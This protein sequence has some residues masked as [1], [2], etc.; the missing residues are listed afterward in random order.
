VAASGN[1]TAHYF[2]GA[3]LCAKRQPQPAS[4][5]LRLVCDTAALL[6]QIVTKLRLDNSGHPAQA[7]KA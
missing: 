1:E 6:N 3:R 2:G 7:A 4:Y 5:A